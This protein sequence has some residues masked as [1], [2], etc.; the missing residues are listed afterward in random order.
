[1]SYS[2]RTC[3][4]TIAVLVAAIVAL[5]PLLDCGPGGCP[6]V[7]QTSHAAH[8]GLSTAYLAAVLVG[9]GA[10]PSL[11]PFLGRR[12]VDNSHRPVETYISP[13]APPPRVFSSC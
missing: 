13:E 7:S 2:H 10:A 6:E 9:S 4:V 11:L 1:M 12:R 5:Y 8:A 3:L